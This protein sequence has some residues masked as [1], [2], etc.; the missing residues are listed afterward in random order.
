MTIVRDLLQK[1]L[2]LQVSKIRQKHS[3][4]P[5]QVSKEKKNKTQVGTVYFM[6]W[7]HRVESWRQMLEWIGR[8]KLKQSQ[9]IFYNIAIHFRCGC[10]FIYYHLDIFLGQPQT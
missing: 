10:K 3:D 6:E 8:L 2:G 5:F 9:S 1:Y 4:A 7:S